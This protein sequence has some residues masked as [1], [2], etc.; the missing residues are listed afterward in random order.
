M[1]EFDTNF[2][3]RCKMHKRRIDLLTPIL[4]GLNPQTGGYHSLQLCCELQYEIGEIYSEM[5]DFKIA[6]AK[7]EVVRTRSGEIF[8]DFYFELIGVIL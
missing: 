1:S 4:S 6:V 5:T 8:Y 7:Q 3:R 2:E